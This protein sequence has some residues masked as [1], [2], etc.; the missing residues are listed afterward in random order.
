MRSSPG[1]EAEP[2]RIA[3]LSD[4]LI[5]QIAAGEVV[6]RPA[7]VVKELIENSL[8]SGATRID[9]HLKDG[10]ISE[11]VVLD[12]GSG[13]HPDDLALC[14]ERHATSK[15][16]HARDLEAIATYGF[17]GEA[18]ASIAAVA[19]VEVVSRP[20]SV[21][22]G[23]R[24]GLAFGRVTVAPEKASGPAGT[25]MTVRALFGEV[26]ARR[27]FLRS[28][29]T[30]LSHA[31]R[32]VRDLALGAPQAR[33]FL[34]H[35]GRPL[36]QYLSPTR[37]GRLGECLKPGWSPI[38]VVE[39]SQEARLEAWL[40]P[41][42]LVQ[43]RGELALFVNGRTVRN[44]SLTGA[45]RSAY[46]SVLGPR[47]EPSGVVHLDLRRDWVD[48][49]VHPQKLE[50]R[51]LK[52][53]SLF[54]WIQ[55]AVKKRLAGAAIL[56]ASAPYPLA[57]SFSG[58]GLRDPGM[59]LPLTGSGSP[60][61]P[62]AGPRYLGQLRSSYLLCEDPLGLIVVDPHA[63][64]ERSRYQELQDQS[65][66]GALRAQAFLIPRVVSLPPD[67]VEMA[68][69]HR[70]GFRNLGFE[71]EVFG[72]GDLMLKSRPECLDDE[73]DAV[74]VFRESLVELARISPQ[75]SSRGGGDGRLVGRAEDREGETYLD[76]TLSPGGPP[77]ARSEAARRPDP[78]P[79][80]K[81]GEKCGPGDGESDPGF[82]ERMAR[83]ILSRVARHST[84]KVGQILS[85]N[86]AESLLGAI[87]PDAEG[88]TCPDGAPVLMRL[89]HAQ[90]EKH[91]RRR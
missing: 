60:P 23:T 49:N 2:A 27:K 77:L 5:N 8:D 90:I 80:Q 11:I 22:V 63:I 72:D 53:E 26:P 71:L 48:V 37:E 7:S 31:A 47:H 39:E 10:G 61:S 83:M 6:E 84:V 44:R 50:V 18:L 35:Q 64:H 45:V 76:G 74:T 14:V 36:A 81:A 54:P 73:G 20:R 41:P 3:R 70:E 19:E 16:S 85:T 78:S 4:A 33:I 57:A 30:E 67:L 21:P 32:M 29:A 58:P 62:A 88:W 79:Q 82:P 9:V 24:I 28:P 65:R 38:E 91:F 12:D 13:I 17:R 40:S 52:Q 25:R 87:G 34:A 1:P 86:E 89:P 69:H 68:L 42:S 55:S 59:E 66:R 46:E 15:I 56:P 43:D 51:C 75:V